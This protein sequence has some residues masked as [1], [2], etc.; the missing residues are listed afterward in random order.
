[1]KRWYKPTKKN[2][3]RKSSM[4]KPDCYKCQYRGEVPGGGE[5]LMG[6]KRDGLLAEDHEKVVLALQ[7]IAN[8]MQGKYTTDSERSMANIAQDAL[9]NFG[10]RGDERLRNWLELLVTHVLDFENDKPLEQRSA[11]VLA[12][13]AVASAAKLEL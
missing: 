4:E 1:M 10:H 6:D 12:A 5:R 8:F 3:G 7:R 13:Q 11:S 9:A 2:N